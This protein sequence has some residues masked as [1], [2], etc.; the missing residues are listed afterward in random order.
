MNGYLTAGRGAIVLLLIVVVAACGG[1]GD[2]AATPDA[3]VDCSGGLQDISRSPPDPEDAAAVENYVSAQAALLQAMA[4]ASP[5][6]RVQA[7]VN[8]KGL[9]R[10]DKIDELLE[11]YGLTWANI[12]WEATNGVHGAMS[13]IVGPKS[14]TELE[15]ELRTNGEIAPSDTVLG[16]GYFTVQQAPLESLSSLQNAPELLLVDIG[17]LD[18]LD[19][20]QAEGKCGRFSLPGPVTYFP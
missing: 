15:S 13:Q 7:G 4:T 1:D 9:F 6:R 2:L 12:Y 3:S 14:M 16:S 17:P 18:E 20:A 10:Q 11:K 19:A 8:L 5:A